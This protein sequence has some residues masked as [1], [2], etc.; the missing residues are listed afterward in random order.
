[1]GELGIRYICSCDL[2]AYQVLRNICGDVDLGLTTHQAAV[3]LKGH[4][5]A[6]EDWKPDVDRLN[7]YTFL[8][9][10]TKRYKDPAAEARRVELV[11]Q[12]KDLPSAEISLLVHSGI[13]FLDNEDG[14]EEPELPTD[15]VDMD[16]GGDDTQ[17]RS[18]ILVEDEI[19]EDLP[20]TSDALMTPPPVPTDG[21]LKETGPVKIVTRDGW[22]LLAPPPGTP[23]DG[24]SAV[25]LMQTV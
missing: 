19:M 6:A 2:T 12:F 23:S 4:H 21:A 13:R 16:E 11:R 17:D 1:M 15:D 5:Q 20:S 22:T 8:A 7:G 18:D 10:F 25:D 24:G 3:P 14:L 9:P